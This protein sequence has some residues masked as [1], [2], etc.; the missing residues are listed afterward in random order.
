[1]KEVTPDA[2]LLG[3]YIRP[4]S[5]EDIEA[6]QN[7]DFV[8][9]MIDILEAE[10]ILG[11]SWRQGLIE[12][13]ERSVF[14][15]AVLSP[16]TGNLIGFMGAAQDVKGGAFGWFVSNNEINSFPRQFLT[17]SRMVYDLYFKRFKYVVNYV[18]AENVRTLRWLKKLGFTISNA[19]FT[20]TNPR[21]KFYAVAKYNEPE[22]E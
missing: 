4:I 17:V 14:S 9:K 5:N 6:V 11:K 16:K 12:S 10:A 19:S 8:L 2:A 3:K 13:I 1:M 20:T 15:Y 18:W 22:W 21:M 7:G